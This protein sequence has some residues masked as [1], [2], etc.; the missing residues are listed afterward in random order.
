MKLPTKIVFYF[1]EQMLVWFRAKKNKIE[2]RCAQERGR[3]VVLLH[4][5]SRAQ[6]KKHTHTH[7]H[8]LACVLVTESLPRT[9]SARAGYH[10]EKGFT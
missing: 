5:Y 1:R 2:M 8:T 7:T 3:T 6:K 10:A 9:R 4:S